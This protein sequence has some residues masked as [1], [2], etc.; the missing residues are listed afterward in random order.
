MN[1]EASLGS[2]LAQAMG[3]NHP[4]IMSKGYIDPVHIGNAVRELGEAW[5]FYANNNAKI[6]AI[7]LYRML[8]GC[9]LKEAKDGVEY[10]IYEEKFAPILSHFRS[11]AYSAIQ[12]INSLVDRGMDR[13]E[14]KD[15]LVKT[16]EKMLG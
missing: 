13:Q 10:F 2:I 5:K 11:G 4:H 3:R 1:N 9:G 15:L 8:Y 6:N 14:A 16:F 7:K 12:A